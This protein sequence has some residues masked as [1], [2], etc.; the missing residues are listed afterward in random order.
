MSS[1][2]TTSPP[3]PA[4]AI[5]AGSTIAV[6]VVF[7]V[8]CCA[9]C[10]MRK[11]ASE[12]FHTCCKIHPCHHWW[13][14]LLILTGLMTIPCLIHLAT[15]TL[16]P[17]SL[18]SCSWSL[19]DPVFAP[20]TWQGNFAAACF[21]LLV[22]E[23]IA[24]AII[25]MCS[26]TWHSAWDM[27]RDGGNPLAAHVNPTESAQ[28]EWACGRYSRWAT[29]VFT[30][31]MLSVGIMCRVGVYLFLGSYYANNSPA[32]ETF[33][34][35]ETWVVVICITLNFIFQFGLFAKRLWCEH[36]LQ[37]DDYTAFL[38]PACGGS[39]QDHASKGCPECYGKGV[40]MELQ[41]AH[42]APPINAT[43]EK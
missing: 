41:A 6:A 40:V 39:G 21:I 36:Q 34:L 38:C 15:C 14:A 23:F 9:V 32:L 4:G 11:G 2:T 37:Y 27:N 22:F 29:I 18:N 5:I 1:W 10:V 12:K 16:Q 43:V 33:S 24:G 17:L 26:T 20:L 30:F 8:L 31:Y 35:S 3:V 42:W 25:A 13:I 19:N 7:I 28:K